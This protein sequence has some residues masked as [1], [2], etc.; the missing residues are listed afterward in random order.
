[1]VNRT[2]G[3]ARPALVAPGG[4]TDPPSVRAR[5]GTGSFRARP[6]GISRSPGCSRGVGLR[7][8]FG[9]RS[10]LAG[11]TTGPPLCGYRGIVAET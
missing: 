4:G 8:P 10:R 7:E 1:M 3:L 5:L 9:W 11:G 6:G 2:A